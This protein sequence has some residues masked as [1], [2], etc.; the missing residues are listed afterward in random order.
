M[1]ASNILKPYLARGEIRMIGA[2]TSEE[3]HRYIAQDRALARRFEEIPLASPT[4]DLLV[5]VVSAGCKIISDKTGVAISESDIKSAVRLTDQYLPNKCQP[6][7]TINLLDL[8]ATK[9]SLGKVDQVSEDLLRSLLADQTGQPIAQLAVEEMDALISLEDRLNQDL[10]GQKAAV[11]LVVK[12]LV[13]RRQM[14]DAGRERN[15]GTFLFSGPTG[16]GKTELGRLLAREFYGGKDHLLHVDLAEYAHGSDI[17]RLIGASPGL[18]GHEKPGLLAAFLREV[19]SGVI[20]FDEIEK[21]APEVR[22]FLLGILDNGRVRTAKGE[23]LSTRG[24][25]IILTTNSLTQEDLK[26]RGF[27]FAAAD[28]TATADQL[29]AKYF[30]PEFLARFDELILFRSLTQ[31]DIR[32]II[33]LRLDETLALFSERGISV[34]FDRGALVEFIFTRLK[35]DGARGVQRGIEKHF[36]QQ[37]AYKSLITSEVAWEAAE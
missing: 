29:L 13:Y 8:A 25:I 19:G 34:T 2:T 28:K 6:D 3:Y 37:V 30:P 5:K 35:D 36:A 12:T 32:S 18:V 16:V 20:L 9:A 31:A 10:I 33:N 21:A 7:K 15:V 24:T 11:R 1:D 27:G 23:L 26:L 14:T 4:G 17:S 22:D